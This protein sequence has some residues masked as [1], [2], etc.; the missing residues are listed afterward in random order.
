MVAEGREWGPLQLHR[1]SVNFSRVTRSVNRLLPGV[2]RWAPSRQPRGGA[3]ASCLSPGSISVSW[4]GVGFAAPA[5][6]R[7]S[8]QTTCGSVSP[9][10][11]RSSSRAAAGS[12]AMSSSLTAG[13]SRRA[14]ASQLKI[15][16]ELLE[17]TGGQ[18]GTIR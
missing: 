1:T 17:I 8:L 4:E 7:F 13:H 12:A 5:K 15:L 6:W 10:H 9:G 18:D 11:S 14:P 16:P 2:D 3:R